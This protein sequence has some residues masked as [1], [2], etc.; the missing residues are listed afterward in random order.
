MSVNMKRQPSIYARRRTVVEWCSPFM[1]SVVTP[2]RVK[3]A[4]LI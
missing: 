3:V 1:V 4:W 2:K